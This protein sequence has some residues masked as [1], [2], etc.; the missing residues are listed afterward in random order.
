MMMSDGEVD[1]EEMGYLSTVLGGKKIEGGFHLEP[2]HVIDHAMQY[3]KT[4]SV[5]EF[6]I[7]IHTAKLLNRDQKL[8]ILTHLISLGFSNGKISVEENHM[9]EVFKTTFALEDALYTP[10][11]SFLKFKYNKALVG[12]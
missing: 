3:V 7:Q 8:F 10:M 12:L 2:S 9:L 1:P 4:H 5:K 6:L 11:L